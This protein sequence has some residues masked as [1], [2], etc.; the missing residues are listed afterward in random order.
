MGSLFNFG[1]LTKVW[2]GLKFGFYGFGFK[3]S[4]FCG[5]YGFGGK[6]TGFMWV[7]CSTCKVWKSSESG[8]DLALT[9]YLFILCCLR[10]TNILLCNVPILAI[11]VTPFFLQYSNIYPYV[12]RVIVEK[13][14]WQPQK[15]HSTCTTTFSVPK[16]DYDMTS[17]QLRQKAGYLGRKMILHIDFFLNFFADGVLYFQKSCV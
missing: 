8:F 3:L 10:F 9:I 12:M 6:T 7:L 13:L 14:A 2:K 11:S 15:W 17:R 1:R 16:S 5:S 4:C